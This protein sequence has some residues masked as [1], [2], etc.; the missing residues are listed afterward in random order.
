MKLNEFETIKK[1]WAEGLITDIEFLLAAQLSERQVASLLN[2]QSLPYRAAVKIE[3][4]DLEPEP[5]DPHQFA[6]SM[7][8]D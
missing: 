3:L 1:Q 4:A 2:A 6:A 7:K 8:K 5:N